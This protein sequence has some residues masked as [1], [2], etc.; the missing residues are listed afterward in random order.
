MSCITALKVD[1]G[2]PLDFW[3]QR[4][5][6]SSM[7]VTKIVS[8]VDLE[9]GTENLNKCCDVCQ[10]AEQTKIGA[11]YFLTI[12]DYFRSVWIYLLIDKK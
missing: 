4:L 8:G 2:M 12:D 5:G 10:R 11:S 3:H 9:K 7:Q 1:K 6:H